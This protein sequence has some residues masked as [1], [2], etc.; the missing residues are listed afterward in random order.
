MMPSP[1]MTM[2][3]VVTMMMIGVIFI[4]FQKQTLEINRLPSFLDAL[5][6]FDF[7][8]LSQSVSER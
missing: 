4:V 2:L 6:S 5:A 8:L 7:T 1:S 3:K